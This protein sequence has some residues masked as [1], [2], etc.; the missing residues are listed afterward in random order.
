MQYHPSNTPIV[1]PR[2]VDLYWKKKP[3][4][5]RWPSLRIQRCVRLYNESIA[6][7]ELMPHREFFWLNNYLERNHLPQLRNEVWNG[8]RPIEDDSQP[9]DEDTDY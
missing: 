1:I 4:K 5:V 7:G 6:S 3:F 2:T 8:R 9:C